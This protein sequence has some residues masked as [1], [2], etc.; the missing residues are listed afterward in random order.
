[1]N[2]QPLLIPPYKLSVIDVGDMLGSFVEAFNN[3]RKCSTPSCTG[4]HVPFAVKL[5]GLGGTCSIS[6][7]C[8]GCGFHRSIN[9]A[10]NLSNIGAS[11]LESF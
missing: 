3:A 11:M 2:T 10:M 5:D 4:K 7:V 8:N 1:M 6:Y 9:Q